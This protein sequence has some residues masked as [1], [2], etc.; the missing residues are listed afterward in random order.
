ME[1]NHFKTLKKVLS[2]PKFFSWTPQARCIFQD[3]GTWVSSFTN[4]NQRFDCLITKATAFL[5]PPPFWI[6]TKASALKV[7]AAADIGSIS[8][9]LGMSQF[10]P[11]CLTFHL[12]WCRLRS[13]FSEA[14]IRTYFL[15]QGWIA[16]IFSR[17]VET[18]ENIKH[19][20]LEK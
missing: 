15:I 13:R 14:S 8:I 2:P 11:I 20:E 16:S 12:S 3:I 5:F 6:R 1:D 19:S 4:F 10:F 18:P 9:D 17:G 7:K